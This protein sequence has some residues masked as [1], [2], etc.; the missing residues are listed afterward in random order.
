MP[1]VH[2]RFRA[3]V[4]EEEAWDIADGLTSAA[5]D[6]D[7]REVSAWVEQER[8]GVLGDERNPPQSSAVLEQR[9]TTPALVTAA[10]DPELGP[11]AV[12]RYGDV[13]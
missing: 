11:V 2:L 12:R 7:F 1:V 6:R 3:N 9:H 10:G 4:T 13:D 5:V 8:S